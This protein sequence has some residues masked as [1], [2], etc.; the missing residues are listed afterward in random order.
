MPVWVNAKIR[1]PRDGKKFEIEKFAEDH[2]DTGKRLLIVREKGKEWHWHI[3]GLLQ[4]G[5]TWEH[6]RT[7]PHPDKAGTQD[8][9][10]SGKCYPTAEAHEL[11]YQ[12]C[13][14][15]PPTLCVTKAWNFTPAELDDLYAKWLAHAKDSTAGIKRKLEEAELVSDDFVLSQLK[16]AR[17]ICDIQL[18]NN[19]SQLMQTRQLVL[20]ELYRRDR[21]GHREGVAKALMHIA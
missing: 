11:G 18:S 15:K 9:P 4:E 3:H 16:L 17:T 8:R 20:T 19:K 21:P 12:Y 5:E 7:Y 1:C 6:A 13:M 10:I 2:F 14:K